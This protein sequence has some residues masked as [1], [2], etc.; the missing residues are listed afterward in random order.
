MR[1]LCIAAV[2]FL[3]GAP[4]RTFAG[5]VC[6]SGITKATGKKVLCECGANARAEA[7]GTTPDY[8][9]CKSK[10]AAACSKAQ[11]AGD[12]AYQTTSCAEKEAQVDLFVRE[13][14]ATF[15][16][17]ICSARCL[18]LGA[19]G[20]IVNTDC[21]GQLRCEQ[22]SCQSCVTVGLPCDANSDC[23]EGNCVGP[24]GYKECVPSGVVGNACLPPNSCCSEDSLCCSG[25]CDNGVCFCFP[26]GSTCSDDRS[27]CG[28]KC[29]GG[30]CCKYSPADCTA[31]SE[32][33]SGVCTASQHCTCVPNGQT[34]FSVVNCCP[35]PTQTRSTG[36]DGG[37]PCRCC[38][39]NGDS[40]TTI[41]GSYCCQDA[42]ASECGP[43]GRCCLSAG[44]FC[45]AGYLCCSGTC[46]GTHHCT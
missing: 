15:E 7:R 28:G 16:S 44:A 24:H 41:F 38:L 8:T 25:H 3:V 34:T 20:C 9:K 18:D 27:C 10:F 30:T 11:S 39:T 19:N 37:P 36:C 22:G 2:V 23:C 26:P 4:G 40:C 46:D 35:S 42:G 43:S 6:D 45:S 33:C 17:G 13:N 12:C 31:G 29:N 1:T 21:C 14:C 32:C 5:S